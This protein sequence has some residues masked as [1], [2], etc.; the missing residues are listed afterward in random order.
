[1]VNNTVYQFLGSKLGVEIFLKKREH[2]K[3]V[4]WNRRLRLPCTLCIW[5]SRK[6]HLNFTLMFQLRYYK[7]VQSLYKNWLLVSNITWGIWTTWDQ[8]WKVQKV[9]I[10]T[11]YK[12]YI[13]SAKT[14]YTEDIC[15]FS[16]HFWNHKSF[17]TTQILCIF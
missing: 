1:M 14:L 11:L 17:F 8:Q 5:V 16:C 13:P 3:R 15:N 10:Y 9:E 6:S 4:H 12:I 7:M 2:K